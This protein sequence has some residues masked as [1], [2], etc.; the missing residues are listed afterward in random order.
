M[1][2]I[3][4]FSIAVLL[5]GLLMTLAAGV[6]AAGKQIAGTVPNGTNCA[7]GSDDVFS[8]GN[9]AFTGN[10]ARG[11]GSTADSAPC[12]PAPSEPS[13]PRHQVNRMFFSPIYKVDAGHQFVCFAY[14]PAFARHD[15]RIYAYSHGSW[16]SVLSEIVGSPARICASLPVGS[17]FALM[18]KK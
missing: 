13:E 18:G 12:N 5:V 14:P 6:W 15:V 10:S 7:G 11:A 8:A 16:Q 9:S 2:R 1:K 3:F 4:R 17:T